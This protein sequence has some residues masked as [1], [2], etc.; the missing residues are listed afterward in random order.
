MQLASGE[1]A[2]ARGTLA[3]ASPAASSHPDVQ[4]AH[5][6]VLLAAGQAAEAVTRGTSLAQLAPNRADVQFTLGL[7]LFERGDIATA[8]GPLRRRLQLEPVSIR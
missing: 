4:L 6:L 3:Q 5:V 8:M 2:T 7:A 1:L